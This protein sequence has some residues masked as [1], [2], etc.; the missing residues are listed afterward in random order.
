MPTVRIR[1]ENRQQPIPRT[2]HLPRHVVNRIAG[3]AGADPRTLRR[4]CDGY[5]IHGGDLV[6]RMTAAL[7]NAGIAIVGQEQAP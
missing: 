3:L 6:D 5:A 4:F 7:R 2:K 1:N